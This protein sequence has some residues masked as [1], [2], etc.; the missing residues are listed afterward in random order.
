MTDV[1][2]SFLDILTPRA[3]GHLQGSA[4]L[5]IDGVGSVML[6]DT[7]A[8]EGDEAADVTLKASEQVFRDIFD[9]K[10]NMVMAFMT[11]KLKVDGS[12]MRALKVGG[13]LTA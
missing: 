13:L 8:R 3:R 7:G 1:L 5:V 6:D 11:G 10:Q 12:E 2:Q 4:K 9:G